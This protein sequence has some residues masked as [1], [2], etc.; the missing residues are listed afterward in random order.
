MK[1]MKK[2]DLGVIAV[3][4][5][6]CGVAFV[7]TTKLDADSQIYPHFCTGILFGFTTL[8][9]LQMVVAAKNHGVESGVK[10]VFADFIPTQFAVCVGSCIAYMVLMYFT[11]FYISTVIFLVCL[12]LYL[13][14]PPVHMVI[15][16]AVLVLLVYLAFSKFLGVRLPEG[17]LF[18]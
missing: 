18:K 3:M 10:E 2:I 8:Y 12:L 17:I 14:T 15:V 16:V 4:Y 9:L 5:I 7:A 11:G 6:I 13:K 1:K